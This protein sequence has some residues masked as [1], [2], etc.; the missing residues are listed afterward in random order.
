MKTLIEKLKA[1]RLYFVRCSY[2]IWNKYFR[3]DKVKTLNNRV[4]SRKQLAKETK[5]YCMNRNENFGEL[6]HP[7]KHNI[8]TTHRIG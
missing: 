7:T 2:F 6:Q 8:G 5:E 3:S 4:Y 1:L